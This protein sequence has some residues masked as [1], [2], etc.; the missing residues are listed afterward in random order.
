MRRAGRVD[1]NHRL[2]VAAFRHW[3]CSVFSTSGAA[4]GFPDVVVGFRGQNRL[5]E[6][7]SL[8]G[9]LTP[10]Q[11]RFHEAWGGWIDICRSAG[12]ADALVAGWKGE[13]CVVD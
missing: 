8:T 3:G 13:R 7:K 12:D 11:L 1:A 6:I 4:S 2:I 9:R 10:D 5:V